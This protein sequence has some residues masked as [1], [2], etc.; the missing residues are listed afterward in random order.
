MSRENVTGQ[1]PAAAN[2]AT[3]D[4]AISNADLQP[5]SGRDQA[6]AARAS[7]A[8]R[9]TTSSSAAAAAP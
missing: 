6:A 7:E 1:I 2:G 4:D 9:Q 3:V 8:M 5:P